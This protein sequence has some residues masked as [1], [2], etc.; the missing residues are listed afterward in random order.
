MRLAAY[1]FATCGN[2]NRNI[3][4]IKKAIEQASENKVDLIIFPECALT[5]YPP[6]DLA[7][8]DCIDVNAVSESIQELQRLADELDIHVIV[9]TIDYADSKYYNRSYLISPNRIKLWY[10]KRALY[11]WDEENFSPGNENGIFEIDGI[12]IGVRICFE[13]RFPEYFRELYCE[14]TD[15]DIVLM[16]DV[17]DKDDETRYQMIRGHLITRAVENV[18]PVL[19]VNAL[20]PNQTAPTC[21][22]NASGAVCK[23]FEKNREGMLIYDF[24]KKELNLGE[25]G[26]KRYSDLL[27]RTMHSVEEKS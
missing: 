16:Y 10:D 15:L 24:E 20:K 8:A 22:I 14:N 4:I 1:Q 21:F 25:L 3:G 6:R 9:G 26:R 12:K 17:S 11:G 19:S 5:G 18:T 2:L 27:S 7:R 13:I 23:E